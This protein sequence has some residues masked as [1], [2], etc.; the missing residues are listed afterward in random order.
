MT[1]SF[2]KFKARCVVRGFLAKIGLDFYATYSP[3]ASLT[4]SRML[5]ALA[6]HHGLPVHHADI[7]QAFIQTE[8][9]RDI[10]I[11]FPRG[12]SVR[13]DLLQD[14]QE[15]YPDSK[16]GIRLLR[17][18]YGLKQA[19]MLWNS[20]LN[21]VLVGAGYERSKNDTSFYVH[22]NGDKFV[23]LAVFVDDILVTGNDTHKIQELKALFEEKFRGD[24]T[25]DESVN[26]F[27]G[28]QIEYSGGVLSM[29]VQA[30]IED[31]FDKYPFLKK[32]S[33]YRNTPHGPVVTDPPN[34]EDDSLT[35]FQVQLRDNFASIVGSCI[36]FSVTCRP[37]IS[38]I[39]GKSCQGMH[40]PK[41]IHVMY[42]ELLVQYLKEHKDVKLTYSRHSLAA[43]LM[44]DLSKR[45]PELVDL[46]QAPIVGFS[47]AN[48]LSKVE[49]GERMRS[50]SGSC[51]YCFGNLVQWSSK[52]QSL[53]AGS[54]MEAEL[55]A[56]SSAADS[57]V[58]YHSFQESYPLIFGITGKPESVPLLID[59]Q[60]ALSVAN[61][62]VSSPRTRHICLREFRI[63]DFHEAGKVR[64]FW[65]PGTHNVADHFSKLLEKVNFHK[66]RAALGCHGSNLPCHEFPP[67][68]P[69]AGKP[70]VETNYSTEF[71]LDKES[72]VYC[73]HSFLDW[74]SPQ[75]NVVWRFWNLTDGKFPSNYVAI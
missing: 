22:T 43:G 65:C 50:V 14:I 1:S 31:L 30:K 29:N 71:F 55:I 39:V 51:F 16:I 59:N 60:A 40:N 56:A 25:W 8:L 62:P 35:D 44:G 15:K 32:I 2:D 68:R 26:S 45:Y 75:A 24:N 5:M 34:P 21:S 73:W 19:P 36:Y 42:L 18:L 52:R 33:R 23:A 46:P 12:V 10:Y 4:T 58:W 7:P 63:R 72:K 9:N 48:W 69:L 49:S 20:H 54:T 61:H 3:M 17:S 66:C 11:K 67:L 47:D 28:M 37:D 64:P 74:K 13:E 53:T 6:V 38:T 70:K 41:K 57:A 27:L